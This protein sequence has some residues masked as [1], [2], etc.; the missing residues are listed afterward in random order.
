MCVQWCS[1]AYH[2]CN[3]WL[4]V[5]LTPSCQSI[6]TTC[7]SF[8]LQWSVCCWSLV[9]IKGVYEGQSGPSLSLTG[10]FFLTETLLTGPFFSFSHHSLQTLETVCEN[11]RRSAVSEI[12]KPPCLAPTIIPRSKSLGWHFCPH[13]DIWSE[14]QLNLL[15]MFACLYEFSLLPHDWLSKYLHLQAG[16]QVYLI[17]CS[18]SLCPSV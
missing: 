15:A 18:L 8:F 12:L 10:C 2:C 16:A 6:I 3:T 17:K 4:F 7:L 11:S 1:P 14:K 5:L 13:S 9:G